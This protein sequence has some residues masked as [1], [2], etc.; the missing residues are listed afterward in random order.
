MLITKNISKSF[1]N[2]KVLEDVSFSP[3]AGK[4]TTILA[5]NGT[6]KSTF[7]KIMAGLEFPDQGEVL[8]H[9][10]EL[11]DVNFPFVNDIFFVHEHLSFEL[12]MIMHDLAIIYSKN[13]SHWN[14]SLFEKMV[15]DTK[16]D[17]HKRFNDYSR[18]QKM[19]FSLMVAIA[20]NPKVLLIDEVTSV[21]DIYARKYFLDLLAEFAHQGGTVVITTNIIEELEHY[22]DY[23]VI[24]SNCKIILNEKLEDIP[25]LFIKIRKQKDQDHLV[26]KHHR[27]VYSGINSDKSES[28]IVPADLFHQFK[29]TD[30]FID[31]RKIS[32]SDIFVYYFTLSTELDQKHEIAV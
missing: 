30:N 32:L 16:F 18:G 29:L 21:I 31:Q 27:C 11:S 13:F 2:K 23:L 28:Y 7:L 4:I 12:P 14:K 10:I 15:K 3:V 26:F 5:R 24:F 1:L 25:R 6:G 8:Y 17:L 9:G 19:Q 22:T 20:S